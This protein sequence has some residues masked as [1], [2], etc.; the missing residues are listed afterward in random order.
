M[1]VGLTGLLLIFL[2]ACS[3]EKRPEGI[4][5]RQDMVRVLTELYLT[6][7]KI[8]RLGVRHDSSIKVFEKIKPK[9]FEKTQVTDSVFH[10]SMRYYMDRPKELEAIYSVLVDSLNLME[11][12]TPPA[13]EEK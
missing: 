3:R 7:E 13:T 8:Q 5:S 10:R 6:E 4:L 11:Q 2:V 9:V 1:K 12:R